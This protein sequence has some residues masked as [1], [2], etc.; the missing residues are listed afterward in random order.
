MGA[1]VRPEAPFTAGAWSST[2]VARITGRKVVRSAVGWGA[3]FGVYV[4]TQSLTYATSYKSIAARRLLVKEFGSNAGIS[5]LVGPAFR[6][7]TVAGFTVWK[8]LTVLTITGAVWG[9][10]IGTRLLRGE[11]EAGRWE[12]LL[13]GR[14]TRRGAALQALV[15]YAA[16]LVA[17]FVTTGLLIVALGR[18]SKVDVAAG[19]ALFFAVAIVA[20]PSMFLVAG[21][22]TSQLAS[23]RRQAAGAAS[24][25]LGASYAIRMVADSDTGLGWLR[26][27]TPLGWVEEMK[28]LTAPNPLALVPITALVVV[29]GL[30]TVYLAGR[31]DLGASTLPD[32]SSSRPHLGLL[33]GP[34][35]LA[36]RLM[37]PTLLG[38]AASIVAYGLLLGS[39]AKAGG[40]AITSS[41]SLRL[42][43]ERLGVSGAEAYLGVALLIMAVVLGFVAAGQVTAARSE[44]STGRLEHLLARPLSRVSWLG[45]RIV[46]AAGV[47]VAGGLLAGLSTWVG[48]ASDHAGVDIT[49]MLQAGLNVVPPSVLIL[50]IGVLVVGA[51][52]R[53]SAAVTY[54]VLVWSLLVEITSGVVGVNHWI[55][56]TSVFHQMAAAPSAPIDWTSNTVMVVVGA[57]AALAGVAAFRRR[58]L[59]GE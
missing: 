31:R 39:I 38:W 4:A 30:L 59:Q 35:G 13:A 8:C 53:M 34:A 11:E 7:D 43:F 14:T 56:D 25:F 46:V 50:G 54:A 47:L 26:W 33:S 51:R 21:A 3:V 45:R 44:E 10:L 32:H 48:A 52:P 55:I 9:I 28:P 37:R 16:G 27:A 5:A 2:V 6:I 20:G 12:L 23:T 22:L 57:L 17:L 41:P 58:D 40:Q 15:A 36:L 1:D 49:T 18:T 29:A 24:A 42:V 19:G